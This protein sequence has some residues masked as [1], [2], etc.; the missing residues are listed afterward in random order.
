MLIMRQKRNVCLNGKIKFLIYD[1]VSIMIKIFV[2]IE[3]H[4]DLLRIYEI[5]ISYSLIY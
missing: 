2:S 5:I 4:E 1:K 3:C